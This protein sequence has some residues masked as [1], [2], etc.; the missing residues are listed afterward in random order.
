MNEKL[1][2]LFLLKQQEEILKAQASDIK[3]QITL[4]EQEIGK[5][6]VFP[7]GKK[8]S[9]YKQDGFSVKVER[10]E[11]LKW[12][13]DLLNQARAKLGDKTFLRLFKYE[14]K[15]KNLAV[16]RDFLSDKTNNDTAFLMAAMTVTDK[17]SVSI[18]STAEANTEINA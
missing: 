10:K 4:L 15:H 18:E 16:L 17:Y 12:D 6:A 11:T 7:D 14:W 13:Q 9:N 2:K 8:T 3:E 5:T 1:H